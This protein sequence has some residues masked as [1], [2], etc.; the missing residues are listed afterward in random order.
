MLDE[1]AR[2]GRPEVV[3]LIKKFEVQGIELFPLDAA[4]WAIVFINDR[5]ERVAAAALDTLR[6]IATLTCGAGNLANQLADLNDTMSAR[7]S[8]AIASMELEMQGGEVDA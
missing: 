3:E 8:H 1:E 6:M 5:G 2:K 7:V 4:T